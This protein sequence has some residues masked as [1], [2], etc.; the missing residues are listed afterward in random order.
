MWAY[1]DNGIRRPLWTGFENSIL[2]V[3]NSFLLLPALP[4]L[5]GRTTPPVPPVRNRS[6]SRKNFARRNHT[7]S[8]KRIIEDRTW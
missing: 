4:S 3:F 5:N 2:K 1:V 7:A 8:G 6:D